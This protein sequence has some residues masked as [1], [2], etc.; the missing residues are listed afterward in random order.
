MWWIYHGKGRDGGAFLTLEELEIML[1]DRKT[2][3]TVMAGG[4]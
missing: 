4:E 3:E 1:K 2:S